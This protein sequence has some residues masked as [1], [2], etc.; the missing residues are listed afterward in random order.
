MAVLVEGI[1]VIIRR[2][3]IAEKFPGGWDAFVCDVPNRTLCADDKL[4]RIGFMSPEDV[5]AYVEDLERHGLIYL[6]NEN[7]I[8]LVV[9][10]Q[11]RGPTTQCEWIEFGHIN[12]DGDANKRVAACQV[13]SVVSH[14][15][16]EL[17]LFLLRER[18]SVQPG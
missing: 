13:A 7:A 15:Q 6:E 14:K 11:I 8:D 10:D 18:G 2:E 16:L 17:F 3:A 4:T 1:S 12:M 5:K 9:V